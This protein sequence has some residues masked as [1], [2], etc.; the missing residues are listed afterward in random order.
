MKR[1]L[2]LAIVSAIT[3]MASA[4]VQV[5]YSKYPDY[6]VKVNPNPALLAKPKAESGRP[7]HFNNAE[8]KYFPPVI[9]QVGGSCGSAAQIGYMFNHEINCVRDADGSIET[10]QYPSHFTWLFTNSNSGKIEMAREIGI[11]DAVT[12]GGRTYS[13]YFGIQDTKDPDFGWMQGYDKWFTA[14]HNRLLNSSN[15]PLSLET[16]EGR[17]ACKQWLWNHQGNGTPGGGVCGI[18]VA[19]GGIWNQIPKTDKNDELG[20][21]GMY[22]V[23]TWGNT[24]DHAMTIIGYDDRIEFDLDGNKVYGE[25]DKD[26]V[27]AWILVNSWG[28]DWCNNGFI[29][30]P[31]KN[32]GPVGMNGSGG[33]WRPEIYTIR[34]DYKPLRTLKIKMDYSKRSEIK[35][36]A[37]VSADLNATKPDKIQEFEHF[38]YGGDGNNDGKDAPTPM[39]GRWI[40]GFHYEPMEFGYDLTDLTASFDRRQPLKYF[41]IIETKGTAD[42][43]GKVYSCSLMDYEF[44]EEGIETAFPIDAQGVDIITGGKKTMISAVVNGE[45][46]NAPRNVQLTDNTLV[47]ERPVTSSYTLKDYKI[48][49]DGTEIGTA[50]ASSTTY[51]LSENKG[52]YGVAATYT[53]GNALI[54]SS[55]TRTS[56]VGGSFIGKKAT[57][58]YVGGFTN[59]GFVVP[60]LF[61]QAREN[62]TIEYWLRPSSTTDWNQ[63]IG[64]KW[65]DFMAHT[66]ANGE[67]VAGWSQSERITTSTKSLVKG[68]WTHIAIVVSGK[69]MTVYLNGEVAGEVTSATENGFYAFGDFPVGVA[70]N[71]GINGYMEEFRVW[72]TARTQREIKSLM[73]YEVADPANTPELLVNLQFSKV[74]NVVADATG[75][76]NIT[77]LGTTSRKQSDVLISDDQ[78][79][80]DFTMPENTLYTGIGISPVNTS[81]GLIKATSWT[82]KEG[83][84]SKTYNVDA[85]VFVFS[86]PGEKT[87]SLTITDYN[88]S[89]STVE[90]S[91]IVTALPKVK[92]GFTCQ[93]S[94]PMGERIS[95]TNTSDITDGTA[96]E[97]LMPGAANE[98]ATTINAAATYLKNGIYNVTLRATNAS[99]TTKYTQTINVTAVA[100]EADFVITPSTIVRGGTVVLTDQSLYSPTSWAWAVTDRAHHFVSNKNEFSLTLNDPGTYTVSLDA[101]NSQGSNKVTTPR[102]VIVCNENAETGLNFSGGQKVTF[103]NPL[104][105]ADTHQFTIDWWMYVKSTGLLSH[106]IGGSKSDML[107]TVTDDGVLHFDMGNFSSQTPVSTVIPSEWHHYAITFKDGEGYIYKDGEIVSTVWTPWIVKIPTMP[108]QFTLSGSDAPM[109]AVIDEFRMWNSYLNQ[110]EVRYFANRHIPNV[111]AAKKD[112]KLALYYDFNQS[113]GNVHDLVAGYEGIRSGFG[114]DGDAWTPSLGVFCLSETTRKDVSSDYLTNYKEPFLFASTTLDPSPDASQYHDILQN[115]KNST[116][117]TANYYED[118]KIRTGFSIDTETNRLTLVTK[119]SN[120]NAEVF[121]HQLYQTV[122]LPAGHYVFGI[123]RNKQEKDDMSYIVVAKGNEFPVTSELRDKALAFDFIDAGE[124]GFS[125]YEPTTLSLG[126]L[127]NT[128]GE[129]TQDFRRFYI[130]SKETNDDFTWT[131]VQEEPEV[132]SLE[133]G[134]RSYNIAGQVVGRSYKGMIIQNGKKYLHR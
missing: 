15:F 12:Y 40:D 7:D 3:I 62:V 84:D 25:K 112:H 77:K 21:T 133:L 102:S 53:V 20:V 58:N 16:E 83:N 88:D 134:V 5:D 101:V 76:Y 55:I 46:V 44:D 108:A 118:G 32:G 95:F 90:H 109:N 63:Q 114:P 35:L 6:S 23:R 68:E 94:V 100:P 70:G 127:M 93:K 19:S 116:W 74:S 131:G 13:R 89:T 129:L 29:Y 71:N 52:T 106:H 73:H 130:E 99:G 54:A 103:N 33:Y 59:G 119:I 96:F 17:E 45:P 97:W 48:Y 49:K 122:T 75:H 91:F 42:G 64:T 51:S 128:R 123:E 111:E 27:G 132:R 107:I 8:T 41:F 82:L 72:N 56:E 110:E 43:N 22:Y 26:E 85:P 36:S 69:L 60:G 31:Y 79:K 65:G 117:C 126:L 1:I 113:S 92:V 11:P 121:D 61:N 30:C 18:G 4:Q 87:L 24:V 2:P 86:T 50:D 66:T 34:K 115:E 124:V 120:F 125:I 28:S 78:L 39:L 37:G 81:T 9:N 67:F 105:I 57:N 98:R 104:T 80:A 14:M 38:R 10:N 47:W